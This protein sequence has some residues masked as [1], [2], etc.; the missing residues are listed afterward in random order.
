MKEASH[1]MVSGGSHHK[2]DVPLVIG[3]AA[4]GDGRGVR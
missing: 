1:L 3:Q 2:A 4:V